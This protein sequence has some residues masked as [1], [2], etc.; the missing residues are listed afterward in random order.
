MPKIF[1][2]A[3][4]YPSEN[5]LLL[6]STEDRK[7][8]NFSFRNIS[9]FV[10][11]DFKAQD[12]D[13]FSSAINVGMTSGSLNFSRL[14]N[15]PIASVSANGLMT[16]AVFDKVRVCCDSPNKLVLLS[17]QTTNYSGG[18]NNILSFEK[19]FNY[20]MLHVKSPSSGDYNATVFYYTL[21]NNNLLLVARAT[22]TKDSNDTFV[23]II[24]DKKEWVADMVVNSGTVPIEG[25]TAR[26][27]L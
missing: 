16:S 17:G 19:D 26:V 7:I 3:Q 14:V 1:E 22:M 4:A 12:F 10:I 21:E 5:S 2:Y 15:I 20:V 6:G 18:I 24:T 25:I 11:E 9:N 13:Y 23:T 8:R 27:L